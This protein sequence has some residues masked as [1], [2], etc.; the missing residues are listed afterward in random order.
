MNQ[1]IGVMDSGIG[2]LT[3]TAELMRQL[4]NETI[5]YFGD[6]LRCPYG[7]R[8]LNE[9]KQFTIEIAQFLVEKNIKML[10]I[11]CNTAT[12]AA[13]DTLNE[14]LSIPVVGVIA[15]GARTAIQTTVNNQVLVLGTE[16]TIKSHAYNTAIHMINPLV[17]VEGRACSPFV[18]F[19][20]NKG[21]QNQVETAH[22]VHQVL[23]ATKE[24]PIDTVILGCT[25]YPLIADS[26]QSFYGDHVQV[27]SSS[28]ETAR[29]VSTVLTMQQAHQQPQDKLP[30]RFFVTSAPQTFKEIAKEW[31]NLEQ[32]DVEKVIL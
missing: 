20:E 22:L 14:H 17:H 4:P 13:I 19:I 7:P 15:P 16:G 11:A 29:E 1:P 3:V 30:H 25:H 2:G 18:P 24:M 6:S 9:V 10:V 28:R 27:I 8:N 32:I 12:A 31:L 5:Y 26:I 21:Y 23:S